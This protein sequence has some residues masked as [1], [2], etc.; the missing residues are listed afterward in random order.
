MRALLPL[1]ALL[2]GASVASAAKTGAGQWP[3]VADLQRSE[4]NY[5]LQCR[6]CH[7]P[8]GGGSPDTT[9][10]LAGSL[11]AFLKVRG[12]R[13]YLAQVPG[14]ANA[15]LSDAELAELLN[16]TLFRFDRA[17]VPARF[18]PYTE[19]EVAHLRR[20]PLRTE[21]PHLRARLIEEIRKLP[22]RGGREGEHREVTAKCDQ[23]GLRTQPSG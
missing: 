15:P 5:M 9:P 10:R 19:K 21:A 6:G 4:E 20:M 3:G 11:A 22:E 16:W 14:F 8:D 13:E 17:N 1:A 2:A 12:G 18:A 7:R 23:S